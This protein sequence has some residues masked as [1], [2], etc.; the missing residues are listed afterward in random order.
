MFLGI[1]STRAHTRLLRN[2]QLSH[3]SLLTSARHPGTC[4]EEVVGHHSRDRVHIDLV[5]VG[6]VA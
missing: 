3:I 2:V 1:H 4:I 5:V 6:A